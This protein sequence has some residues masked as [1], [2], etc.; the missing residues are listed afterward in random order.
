[1]DQKLGLGS[2][3]K[4]IFLTKKLEDWNQPIVHEIV[5]YFW[6][7]KVFNI[8]IYWDFCPSFLLGGT[9]FFFQ[10]LKKKKYKK[11]RVF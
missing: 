1:M 4:I 5:C 11:A 6:K 10:M 9:N 8:Q 3:I 7:G 2:T